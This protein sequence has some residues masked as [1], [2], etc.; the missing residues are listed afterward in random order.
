M[1]RSMRYST[2]MCQRNRDPSYP[3]DRDAHAV[4]CELSL[5]KSFCGL[6]LLLKSP[7]LQWLPAKVGGSMNPIA[8]SISPIPTVDY[9]YTQKKL[10]LPTDAECLS[11]PRTLNFSGTCGGNPAFPPFTFI[12][13]HRYCFSLEQLTMT[14]DS[15][16][17]FL[18]VLIVL[19]LSLLRT[20]QTDK[21]Q[22]S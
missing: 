6:S 16:V 8:V 2:T 5:C 4:G 17:N 22:W 3:D 20:P 18:Y 7:V 1:F 14:Q 21:S 12:L 15:P 13:Y 19:L 9:Q 10:D 11:T